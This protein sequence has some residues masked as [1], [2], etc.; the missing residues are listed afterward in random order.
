MNILPGRD[1][2]VH[3]SKLG[4]GKRIN[5]VE[6]VVDLG[7]EIEVRVDD[8]DPNG[9]VSLT[10]IGDDDGAAGGGDAGAGPRRARR[11]V[12]VDDAVATRQLRGLLRRRGPRGLR[13]PRPRSGRPRRRAAAI[14]ATTPRWPTSAVGGAA[15][16]SPLIQTTTLAS[17]LRVVTERMP[18]AH[19]VAVGVWVGVGARDEPAELAGVSHFLEHLLFKGTEDRSARAIA[20]GD[21]PRRRRHERLHDEGVHRLLHAPAGQRRSTSGSR[22]W[23]TCSRRRRCATTTS[24]ASAR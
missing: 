15:V 9:K 18:E 6:D 4:R 24:R 22:S 7:D 16:A 20:D 17:G 13:R 5:R 1:G 10:P 2:L 14:A 21:R 12:A 3:I 11:P 23:A 19:S 8:I